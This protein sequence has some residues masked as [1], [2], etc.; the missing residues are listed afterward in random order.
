MTGRRA[1]WLLGAALMALPAAAQQ[2][3][4]PAQRPNIVLVIADDWGFSDPGSFGSE[5]ATPTIDA[6]A[7]RG[8]RFAN[9]HVAGSCSPTR[10][11]LLTGVNSHRAGLGNMPETIPPDHVGQPGYNAVLAPGVTTLAQRLKRAGYATLY[12]GKWHL[13][14]APSD[15]PTARGWDHALALSQS[16]ADNWENKPNRLLYERA[17]WTRDGRTAVLPRQFYSSRLLVD[18]AIAQ[19]K[20]AGARPF[21]LTIGFLANHIPVQA[22]DADIAAYRGRY[23]GG[24]TA[25][26][27]ARAAGVVRAGLL[28]AT[29][30][31]AMPSTRNW[32]GLTGD[33][34]ARWAGAME[35]Y[36]AMA[37]AMDRELGRLVAHLQASGQADN[38][39]FVFVS[40]NGAEATNPEA[41]W[42]TTLNAR[43]QYDL[44][45]DHQGRPGSFTYIGASWASAAVSPLKGYKFSASEGGV[46]VPFIISLP[47]AMRQARG[48]VAA[49]PAHA[50]DLAPTL[51]DAAGVAD[52]TGLEGRSLL[53]ALADPTASIHG[54]QQAIG[55]E[56]S[57]NAVLY[58][59]RFKLVKNLPPYGDGGWHLYDIVNDPAET[60]D[61]AQQEPVRFAAMQDEWG[62]WA[63]R[64]HVLPMPP[65]YNAPDQIQANA[66]RNLLPGRL[67]PMLASL[68]FLMLGRWTGRRWRRA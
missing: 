57:G 67:A 12:A 36:G 17:E 31:V 7:R 65:G 24:W 64:E 21:F 55:Y 52:R 47:P 68:L 26:R 20:G 23:D 51:L 58:Q 8:T 18:E 34:R 37:T 53:P 42:F 9:F 48:A 5:I 60:R 4:A 44:A 45:A 66:T 11:M 38:T 22:P 6:L 56:L 62:N 1:A 25:L 3:A 19:V 35:A 43:L 32:Q 13:G 61:L 46:R 59:G 40:D 39:V 54:D 14:H 2:P 30:R 29:R 41:T 49:A 33:E 27:A 16:G 15:L 10:A 50:V 28:P 63:A